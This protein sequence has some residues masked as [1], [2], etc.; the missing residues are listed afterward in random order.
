MAE[1]LPALLTAPERAGRAERRRR[2]G[3]DLGR[4]SLRLFD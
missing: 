1:A 4:R 2:H 3:A